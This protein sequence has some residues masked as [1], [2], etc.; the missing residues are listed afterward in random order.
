MYSVLIDSNLLVLLIVGATEK[1]YIAQHK[2]TKGFSEEDYDILVEYL[3]P[4]Q[5]IWITSY[6]LSEVS[7]LL[8]QTYDKLA[9]ELMS[10]LK[11]KISTFN[12]AHIPKSQI[13]ENN[14][15]LRLGVA[16]TSFIEK[17]KKVSCSLTIDLDL[18][19]ELQRLNLNVK[20]FNHIRVKN[21]S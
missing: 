6:C 14:I 18:C 5:S 17:A 8:R 1:K 3:R 4:F 9:L 16:D 20:N 21:W 11:E 10:V 7:N 2:R 13:I 19:C 12:E 15:M